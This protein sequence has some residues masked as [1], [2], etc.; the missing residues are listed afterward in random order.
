MSQ[1]RDPS[2]PFEIKMPL[3]EVPMALTAID[4]RRRS[5]TALTEHQERTAI[6]LSRIENL[7]IVV[8]TESYRGLVAEAK[9]GLGRYD[10]LAPDLVLRIHGIITIPDGGL[11]DDEIRL[12]QDIEA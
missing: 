12:R 7:R 8:S 10:V 1:L 4:V 2:H 11:R 6:D 9:A 3:K 5:W